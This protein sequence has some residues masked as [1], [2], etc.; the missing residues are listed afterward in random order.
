MP[1]AAAPEIK[2]RRSF[3]IVWVVPLVA[4]LIGAWLVFKAVTEKGP[5]ITISFHNAEGL[6]AGKTKIKY[7]DVDI[8]KVEAITIADDLS[9]VILTAQMDKGAAAFLTEKTQFWVVRARIG[10]GQV[11]GLGTLFSGAYIG[12]IPASEGKSL[13]HFKGLEKPPIVTGEVP[14][15]KFKLEALRL[16]S[17]N[18]TSPVFFRQIKVGE[19]T[20]FALEAG[21]ESVSVEIFIQE[22]YHQFVRQNTRFWIASGLDV[23]LTAGG[24]RID[25]ESVTSLLIGGV[26][27]GTFPNEPPQPEAEEGTQFKLYETRDEA[28]DDRFRVSEVFYIK[29]KDSVRGLSLGAPVEFQGLQVGRVVDIGLEADFD[30]L[31]FAIPVRVEMK[32]ERWSMTVGTEEEEQNRYTRLIAKGLRAQLKTGS[33]LTGQLFVDLKFFENAPP[34]QMTTHKGLRVIPSMPSSS[35]EIMEGVT[36]FVKKLDTLPLEDIGRNLQG[37]VAGLNRLVNDPDLPKIV[38]KLRRIFDNLETT[39]QTLNAETVPRI[40]ANLVEM[41]AVIQELDGWVSA[42]APLQ[43]DLRK[44]LQELSDAARAISELADL[45]ERHPEALIQGKGNKGR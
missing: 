19:V 14:G 35:Q 40:N 12:M 21:G 18:P 37:S 36:R 20:D 5:T 38:Q 32:P 15:R 29:F 25:T 11:T 10:A 24:L 6:E 1:E 45:L 2:Q 23:S 31:D 17:L 27:F 41:H 9:G 33:L 42:D 30:T 4:L 8:G 7:K 44:T 13:R 22:P 43:G 34:A 39:T 26:A 16:G 28:R 3:S